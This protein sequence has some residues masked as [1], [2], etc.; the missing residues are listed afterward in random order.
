LLQTITLRAGATPATPPQ[1]ITLTPVTVFVGPNNSGKSKLLAELAQ[2]CASGTQNEAA[3]L[4]ARASITPLSDDEIKKILRRMRPP[5][6]PN[7]VLAPGNVIL[8]S[9]HNRFQV[10]LLEFTAALLNPNESP[11]RSNYACS[12]FLRYHTL[13]LDAV[14]R[15]TLINEGPAGDLLADGNTPIQ[16]LFRKDDLRSKLREKIFDAFGLYFTI[17]PTNVPNLR[18]KLSPS[19]PRSSQIER[20]WSQESVDFHSMGQDI[21]QFSDGV[22]AFTGILTAV[23]A[24]DPSV[25]LADE[26][27]AFLHPALSFKLGKD[28]AEATAGSK[29]RLIVATHSPDFVMGCIQSGSPVNIIRLTYRSGVATA[30]V[31]A[32]E[33]LLKLMRNPLLRSTGVLAALFYEFVVVTEADADRAFYQEINERLVRFNSRGVP[34]TLFLNAQN[35][36]TVDQIIGPLRELGIPAAAII[37]VDVVKEGGTVFSRLLD[38]AF[39]PGIT[40]QSLATARAQIHTAFKA[41]G[42]D[43]VTTGGVDILTGSEREAAKEFFSRLAEYGVFVVERGALESW[44]PNLGASFHKDEWLPKVFEAMGEDPAQPGY[45]KGTSD[46]VW[47]FLDKI[48]RWLRDPSRKG[49][50]M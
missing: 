42:K 33:K 19:Q 43:P 11:S 3:L 20:G 14:T 8:K 27:E 13:M 21:Q 16:V 18:I 2:F 34:N 15:M 23:T 35:R 26:P 28:I 44:L 10:S 31:L 22:K 6:N 25:I 24:G 41:T 32:S 12:W 36:Q 38:S 37:D 17:D 49:I 40:K 50:P 29:K 48:A 45:V 7:E 39:V 47:E 5:A 1:A 9:A 30:R 46:D 4:L